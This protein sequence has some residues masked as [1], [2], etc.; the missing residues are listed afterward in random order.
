MRPMWGLII[1]G[2]VVAI[3]M[4]LH[5]EGR[6]GLPSLIEENGGSMAKT[7][8]DLRA[9]CLGGILDNI[10]GIVFARPCRYDT[11]SHQRNLF[12]ILND[13]RGALEIPVMMDV[14]FGHT[15]PILTIPLG[16]RACLDAGECRL[17]VTE[18]ALLEQS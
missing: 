11:R 7:D 10:K 6:I 18:N 9:L 17:T 1:G 12:H 5:V 14:A 13:I 8:R 3:A 16:V 4:S 2:I 15:N